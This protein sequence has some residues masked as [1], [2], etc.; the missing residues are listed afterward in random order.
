MSRQSE[1]TDCNPT[2]SI[3]GTTVC[4]VCGSWAWGCGGIYVGEGEV[5]VSDGRRVSRCR[6]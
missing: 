2:T 3:T 6:W 1:L 5:V 4:E